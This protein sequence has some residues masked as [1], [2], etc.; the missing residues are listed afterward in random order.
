MQLRENTEPTFNN[1][2]VFYQS[3]S[4]SLAHDQGVMLIPYDA[5]FIL[6]SAL[7][8]IEDEA[9]AGI[10]ARVIMI[11]G[12]VETIGYHAFS[13][14]PVEQV[15][16]LNANTLMGGLDAFWKSSTVTTGGELRF[17]HYFPMAGGAA[18]TQLP[19]A[20][21]RLYFRY[22]WRERL[23][24]SLDYDFRSSVSGSTFGVWTAPWI[25]N[26]GLTV[27]YVVNRH[28]TLYGKLGNLFN[29]R[30]QY[31]PFYVEPGFNF[32]GGIALIF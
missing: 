15:G 14:A 3:D 23:I 24:G 25:H 27:D 28:F 30:N 31:V 6:P 11:T 10:A 21:G 2:A 13:G 19:T 9:F 29:H 32:G 12:D 16:F 20:T 8:T 5:D 22:N 17:Y 4:A 26:L 7:I 1:G 18:V